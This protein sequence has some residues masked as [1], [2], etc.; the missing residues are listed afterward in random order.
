[1]KEICERDVFK[2]P[3]STFKDI[4]EGKRLWNPGA[5]STFNRGETVY[6]GTINS[7]DEEF[8][9]VKIEDYEC[10]Q[11]QNTWRNYLLGEV[12]TLSVV[13]KEFKLFIGECYIIED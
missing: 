1:M 10:R 11:G 5:A 13:S 9:E 4:K 2:V 6:I 12:T 7:T 3:S 8:I